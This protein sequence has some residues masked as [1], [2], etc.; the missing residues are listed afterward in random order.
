MSTYDDYSEDE[1][2]EEDPVTNQDLINIG[3]K[4][5]GRPLRCKSQESVDHSNIISEAKERLIQLE[6]VVRED[7]S[8]YDADRLASIIKR[9]EQMQI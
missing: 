3:M 9:I 8:E 7:G 1:F 2:D 5:L 4:H 6:K